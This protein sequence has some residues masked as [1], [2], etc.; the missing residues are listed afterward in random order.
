MKNNAEPC[1]HGSWSLNSSIVVCGEA[2]VGLH[3]RLLHKN[4]QVNIM[5]STQHRDHNLE[6][7]TVAL[8]YV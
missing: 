4:R 7:T 6:T 1:F 8:L 5:C 3:T 2:G